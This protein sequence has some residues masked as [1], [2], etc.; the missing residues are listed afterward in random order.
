MSNLESSAGS[1]DFSRLGE[2]SGELNRLKLQAQHS[3][4]LELALLKRMGLATGDAVLDLACGPGVMTRLMAQSDPTAKITGMDLNAELL[5]AAHAEAELAG[6]DSIRFVQGDVYSPPF[7]PGQFD[8]IYARLLFQHLRDPERA[9]RSV[10]SLLRPGGIFCIMDI[11]DNW[12]ALH[13][14]PDGFVEFTEAVAE[15]Q[16]RQ[17]GNRRIGRELGSMLEQAGYQGV[18]VEVETLSSRQLGMRAFLDITLGFKRL[19]LQGK[20]LQAAEQ[21]LEAAE[22]LVDNP[23]AWAFVGVFFACGRCD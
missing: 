3:A 10:L 14:C 18:S 16:A 5:D 13:P 15:A 9:M 7:E 21:V 6:C 4:N 19:L 17:G 20:Q 8:F 12:L 11:D 1:Y 2:Q 23:R 22:A